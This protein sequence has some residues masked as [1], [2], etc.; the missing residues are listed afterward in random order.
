MQNSNKHT[1]QTQDAA[2]STPTRRR[3][4]AGSLAAP[5]VLTVSSAVGRSRTT[6]TA[7]LDNARLQP[8]PGQ[9]M[10]AGLNSPDEWLR[11]QVNIYEIGFFDKHG[12]LKLE[13]GNY[14]IGPDKIT[15]HK[16]N[17]LDAGRNA[18]V[19]IKRFNAHSP[20]LHKRITGK[21]FALAYANR[22]GE[23]VGFGW[24]KNGGAH[25]KKSCFASVIAQAKA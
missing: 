20:G 1:A 23:I 15:L 3:V 13:P 4:L 19:P 25:C 17:D 7:C 12:Q 9:I 16:L 22:D 2:A 21:R 10:A 18:A 14:F 11:V 6:F 5:L 8:L 24:E